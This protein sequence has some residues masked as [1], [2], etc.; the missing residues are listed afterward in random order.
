MRS[1]QR[2]SGSARSSIGRK[3]QA[4]AEHVPGQA[5]GK[6]RH[7]PSAA[8]RLI[9]VVQ[10]RRARAPVAED[11]D[12]RRQLGRGAGSRGAT[13]SPRGPTNGPAG[14]RGGRYHRGGAE[15][16]GRAARPESPRKR[17]EIRASEGMRHVPV[18]RDRTR[19][20][21]SARAR[22]RNGH[23]PAVDRLPARMNSRRV[24]SRRNLAAFRPRHGP[25]RT[26]LPGCIV[27]SWQAGDG[28]KPAG[29]ESMTRLMMTDRP[30]HPMAE[31]FVEASS[32]AT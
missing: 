5:D 24:A 29:R 3:T 26:W 12:G 14:E 16:V 25:Y 32:A 22:K 2:C 8:S 30:L 6:R 31:K 9:D 28:A 15:A 27:L 19:P 1:I 4:E 20:Q 11:E 23:R 21:L 7:V 18:T 17:T 13:A 10:M